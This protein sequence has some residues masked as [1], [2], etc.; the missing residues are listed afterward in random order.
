MI[1]DQASYDSY[2][3]MDHNLIVNILETSVSVYNVSAPTP[4]QIDRV[5]FKNPSVACF[6]PSNQL[7]GVRDTSGRIL[8]YDL[9]KQ[10]IIV[11]QKQV[12]AEEGSDLYFL[13]EKL[14]K[15]LIIFS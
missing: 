1:I 14:T 7:L 5:R 12:K 11:K 10:E 8:V 15:F 13:D 6:T 3:S 4:R 2:K 9:K